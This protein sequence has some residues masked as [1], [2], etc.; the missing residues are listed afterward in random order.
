MKNIED[1]IAVEFRVYSENVLAQLRRGRVILIAE[2]ILIFG[3]SGFMV[4]V[5]LATISRALDGDG[6]VGRRLI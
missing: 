1:Q 4:W 2:L 5:M 3:A 6:N